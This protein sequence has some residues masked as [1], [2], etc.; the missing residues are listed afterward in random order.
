MPLILLRESKNKKLLTEEDVNPNTKFIDNQFL[1]S[2]K[3]DTPLLA[4]A[5]E[6]KLSFSAEKEMIKNI[7]FNLK[8]EEFQEYM[9]SSEE[10]FDFDKK[11]ITKI[12]SKFLLEDEHFQHLLAEKNLLG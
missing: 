5:G 6:F 2:L 11:F 4:L 7:Y 3:D 8:T 9:Y 1:N 10:G 12:F